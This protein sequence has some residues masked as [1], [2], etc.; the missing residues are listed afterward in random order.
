MNYEAF[1]EAVISVKEN[2]SIN[3]ASW[4]EW[5]DSQQII[6]TYEIKNA[7]RNTMEALDRAIKTNGKSIKQDAR[8]AELESWGIILGGDNRWYN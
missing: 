1:K 7:D 2:N 4:K 5:K 6:E 8:N 3:D